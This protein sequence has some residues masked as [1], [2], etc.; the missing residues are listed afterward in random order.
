MKTA[1]LLRPVRSPLPL[2]QRFPHHRRQVRDG[3][4]LLDERRIVVH[5]A[6]VGSDVDAV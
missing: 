1:S 5:D 3:K 4:R 6:M 2:V